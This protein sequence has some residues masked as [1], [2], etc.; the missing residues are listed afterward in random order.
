MFS[1]G[2]GAVVIRAVSNDVGEIASLF[3]N[4]IIAVCALVVFGALFLRSHLRSG[5]REGFPVKSIVLIG[6]GEFAGF[7]SFVVGVSGGVISLV[8]TLASASP[9][10][11]VVLAR[12]FLKET[13]SRSHWYGVVLVIAGIL[14]L[15]I[16]ST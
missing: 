14:L 10:V 2:L 13:L 3:F 8:A 12:A 15:S 11:T 6:L 4:R 5:V 7:L 16:A 9:A 1:A